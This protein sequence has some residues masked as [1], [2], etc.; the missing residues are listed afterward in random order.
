MPDPPLRS[1]PV[2][3][4]NPLAFI[5]D[6]FRRYPRR[7][8]ILVGL[9][10]LAG[11]LEG[12][13][14]VTLLPLLEVAI[15]H[16]E[17]PSGVSVY[18][19]DL[20]QSLGVSPSLYTFLI[21]ILVAVS[22]KA[23]A[24]WFAMTRTAMIVADLMAD[25]RLG[26]MSALASA[27]SQ[28][29]SSHRT[30]SVST[31]LIHETDRA[32]NAFRESCAALAAFLQIVVYA[33]LSLIIS[34]PIAILA[35]GAG[36][37]S[38]LV[39]S[40]L[41]RLARTAGDDYHRHVDALSA[42]LVDVIQGI[43]PIKAMGLED[44]IMPILESDTFGLREAQVRVAQAYETTRA[45]QEPVAALLMAA[46]I[47]VILHFGILSFATVIV[48]AILFYRL[49]GQIN[50][51]HSR[52]QI[53]SAGQ[54]G[55]WAIQRLMKSL[56]S[57][58]HASNGS[59]RLIRLTKG[60]QLSDVSFGYGNHLVLDSVQVHFP[61]GSFTAIIG[62]SGHGKTTLADLVAGLI[63][64]T[65][66][67]IYVDNVPLLD[68]DMQSW[69]RAIGYVPQEVLLFNRSIRYNISFGDPTVSDHDIWA[70]LDSSGAS[71]FVS[72]LP[73]GLSALVG[74]R[75]SRLSG[76]QRQRIAI[77]RALVRRPS[78][79]IL[80]EITSALDPVTEAEIIRG[81]VR[82]KGEVTILFIS[83]QSTVRQYADSVIEVGQGGLRT[84]EALSS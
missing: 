13:G 45:F 82:L 67:V 55:Y 53:V 7:S 24:M 44:S 10:A 50:G 39:F 23:V 48:L 75:G 81:L 26:I 61:A 30:G 47:G 4:E 52:Y 9:L 56:N 84:P 43:K 76:G 36:I 18:I 62:G 77:A 73:D 74:E 28:S 2:H 17:R 14:I 42:Q 25:W 59:M 15:G 66:G 70:A 71:G 72:K 1:R 51:L 69:R 54:S 37:I 16:E 83:H 12:I 64:P 33:V 22:L 20:F 38:F 65:S 46:G 3:N 63:Q 80:D 11:L 19:I 68:M 6:T 49:L 57:D 79:L 35:A 58:R 40:R 32:G 41:T 21:V 5:I 34:L 27:P 60:I 78:L 29:F 8:S 31:T